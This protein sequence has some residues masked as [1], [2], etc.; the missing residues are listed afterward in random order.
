MSQPL[1]DA[2]RNAVKTKDPKTITAVHRRIALKVDE[3]Y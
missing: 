1:T 3:A 2:A